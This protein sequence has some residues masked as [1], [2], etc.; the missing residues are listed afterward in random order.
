[1]VRI[2]GA[3]VDPRDLERQTTRLKHLGPDKISTWSEGPIAMAQLMMRITREDGFDIQ[4]V[5]DGPFTLVA[6]VR[7]DNREAL[8][9]ALA[10]DPEPL[11]DMPDSA[12]LMRAWRRWGEATVERLLGDFVFAVWDDEARTLTLVRDH[13]GQRHV[14]YHEGAGLFAFATE[15][16]GLWALPDVPRELIEARFAGG[17]AFR[18]EPD[19]GATVY[20]GIR[21]LPGG[22]IGVLDAKGHFAW[23]RYWEPHADPAH[24]GKDEAYY[25]RTYREVL[26]EAVACRLRRA[27]YPGGLLMGGG[28]DTSGIC[29]L[30]GP[31]VA[32]Q[33]RKFIAA[34]SVMPEDYRGTIR[35]CRQWVEI[36]R[37]HM[38]YLDVRYVTRDGLDIFTRMEEG[39]LAT[40][41][42]HSPNRYVT[43]ALY[44]AIKAG[45]AR[46]VMDGF[47]GDY[48][49]NPR[50]SNGLARLFVRGRWRR[51]FTE[52]AAVKRRFHL[53]A[54]RTLVRH[55]L[56][57]ALLGWLTRARVNHANGLRAFGRTM[58]LSKAVIGAQGRSRSRLAINSMDDPREIMLRAL[59]GQQN[60]PAIAGSIPAA[61]HGL[62]FTQPF[63]DKRVVEFGLAIPED[64]Y[65]KDGKERWLARTALADL[66]PPEFQDRMP[67]NDDLGP[68]FLVMAKRVE[69]RVLAEIERMEKAGKLTK[70]FDFPR[71]RKMLTRRGLEDHNSGN[72][73]DTR[74]AQLA[75]LYARYIEWFR[76]DNA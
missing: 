70:Y 49:V 25:V 3:A 44:D 6:D 55:V 8:A 27:L 28:F 46:I 47:G 52:F 35:H 24:E 7:L 21:A 72:E 26:A 1:M 40:D 56:S 45:G 23:R 17:L 58:P 73:Y 54:L 34:A 13:M 63:H 9:A 19:V 43:D 12:L 30:A 71:M 15:I 61:W 66:Y 33:G 69:P 38:P 60:A 37:R 31:A 32:P 14:F 65:L 53:G 20:L 42:A 68:D 75:F 64:L 67:G 22:A 5:H 62:E 4:P 74:Q 51:F 41:Q 11:A 76:G 18:Q 2:D 50:A 39:F 57:P 36:C 29:A 59:H 48:T 16:K 10:I